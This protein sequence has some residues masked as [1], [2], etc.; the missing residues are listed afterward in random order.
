VRINLIEII[1]SG[2]ANLGH[3]GSVTERVVKPG[4]K[5]PILVINFTEII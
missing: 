3:L 1:H 5:D 2:W 4:R